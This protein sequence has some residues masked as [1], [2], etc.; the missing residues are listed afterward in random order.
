MVSAKFAKIT[1]PIIMMIIQVVK[2]ALAIE[3]IIYTQDVQSH[4]RGYSFLDVGS[5]GISELKITRINTTLNT[6]GYDHLK[7][8]VLGNLLR[9]AF[10]SG[11]KRLTG[12]SLV[13]CQD[14]EA[15]NL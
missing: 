5:V 8:R 1:K 4:I 3:V 2:N 15:I 6:F 14:F 11:N 10:L 7:P 12:F 9:D 13:V